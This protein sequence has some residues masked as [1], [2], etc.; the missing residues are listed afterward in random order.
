MSTT[1]ALLSLVF[2]F[3]ILLTG[4][5]MFT[6]AVEWLGVQLGLGQ[7]AVGSLL[8]AVATA[9]PET[10]IPIV[11]VVGGGAGA[12]Q[13]ATGAIIGAPFMLATLALALVG[14]AAL[15]YR[16]RRPQ[17]SR[18]AVHADTLARDL[19]FFA[20]CFAGGFAL[21]LFAAPLWLRIL[22]AIL[23]VLAYAWYV[24]RTLVRGGSVQEPETIKPLLFDL[25]KGDAPSLGTVVAQSVVALLAIVGG[26]HLFVEALTGLAEHAGLEPLV[27]SLVL[28]PFATELPEKMN[29]FFW[30]REGKDALALGNITGAMV[31]QATLPVAF[32]LVFADWNLDRYAIVAGVLALCGGGLAAFELRVRERFAWRAVAAWA[33]L[34]A[35]FVV[36]VALAA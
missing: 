2:S 31:L 11:A 19:A 18:L 16:R 32:G 14:A 10:L 33:C 36:Y 28:A 35:A 26:A 12:D 6:N 34:Y 22:G 13:V 1:A 23:L 8:A 5:L 29:S 27:L 21:G 30:A 20:A 9:L 17:G 7:G 15:S 4:A 24:Q 3:A 25:T